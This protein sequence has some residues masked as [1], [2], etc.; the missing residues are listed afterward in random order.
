MY[1]TLCNTQSQSQLHVTRY[2]EINAGMEN[3][4]IRLFSEINV[5]EKIEWM[6]F[7]GIIE[8]I[9]TVGNYWVWNNFKEF[10]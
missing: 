6:G 8:S 2:M 1:N 10:N 4:G 7:N 5:M 9:P 3:Q